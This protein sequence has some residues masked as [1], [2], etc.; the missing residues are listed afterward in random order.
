M[1]SGGSGGG[2]ND[3]DEVE[4]KTSA[5]EFSKTI[6]DLGAIWT[7]GGLAENDAQSQKKSRR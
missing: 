7:R 1:Q 2:W 6:H 5:G 3:T 4:A